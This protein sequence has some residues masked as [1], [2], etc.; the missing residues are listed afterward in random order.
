MMVSFLSSRI[1][2]WT[3]IDRGDDGLIEDLFCTLSCVSVNDETMICNTVS[4]CLQMELLSASVWLLSWGGLGFG[5]ET[6][7]IKWFPRYPMH[8]LHLVCNNRTIFTWGCLYGTCCSKSWTS[9]GGV[10]VDRVQHPLI[11]HGYH[12][13]MPA[14]SWACKKQ[15]HDS[16]TRGYKWLERCLYFMGVNTHT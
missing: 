13:A 4:K 6:M 15:D 11:W 12:P 14:I 2:L 8:C 1:V 5:I 7:H 3:F 16:E 9:F 10:Q